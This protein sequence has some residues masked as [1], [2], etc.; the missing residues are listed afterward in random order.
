MPYNNLQIAIVLVDGTW[1]ATLMIE[2]SIGVSVQRTVQIL[3]I[4]S[5]YFEE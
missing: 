3:R 1:L 2:A 4:D 5:D